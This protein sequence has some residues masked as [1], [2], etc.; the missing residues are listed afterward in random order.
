MAIVRVALLR[1]CFV[2]FGHV[3][4]FSLLI[5]HTHISKSSES[6]RSQE[7]D[8][9]Q[10]VINEKRKLFPL[11]F[12]LVYSTRVPHH[13]TDQIYAQQNVMGETNAYYSIL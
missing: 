4:Y 12:V 1:L 3:K 11:D 13:P 2:V 8:C 6:C 7:R 10:F 9:M 5:A